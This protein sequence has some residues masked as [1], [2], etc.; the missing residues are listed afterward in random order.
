MKT[1]LKVL[2]PHAI[3]LSILILVNLIY[4][5]PQFQGKQ[6]A[7]GDVISFNGAYVEIGK[8]ASEKG[9]QLF[10]TN[11][12]F[13]GMPTYMIGINLKSFYLDWVASYLQLKFNYPMGVFLA[14]MIAFYILMTVMG[15]SPYLS[16]I[17]AIAFGF[18]TN[19]FVLFEAGHNTK[20][21]TIV[22][23]PLVLAGLFLLYT[24]RKYIFGG[25]LFSVATA[26][27]LYANHPQMTY[28]FIMSC[29]ILAVFW[30]VQ[31]IKEKDFNHLAKT[32]LSVTIGASLA[33]AATSANV[34]IALDYS[35]DTLRGK[36]I[37]KNEATGQI[38]ST[39]AASVENP[40]DGLTWDYAMQW[41]NNF[42]DVLSMLIPSAAGGSSNE[43][44]SKGETFTLLKNGGNAV[45]SNGNM[46]LPLYCGALPFTSGP[47]Y[48]GASMI[49]LF[50]LGF[51]LE[52]GSL[53]W[54]L[55]T[56]FLL[57]ALL[58][59]GKNFSMLQTLFFDYLPLYN[60]FRAPSSILT[61]TPLFLPILGI[62]GLN[63][64]IYRKYS[65]ESILKSLKTAFF[66]TGG[67][68]LFFL[69]FGTSFFGFQGASDSQ[70]QPQLLTTLI[71]DRKAFF[72]ADA[73]RSLLIVMGI[74][75]VI[76][77]F[78]KNWF[79]PSV[80]ILSIGLVVLFDV[81]GIGARY[82]SKDKFQ[83]SS[84]ANTPLLERPV[85][86]QIKQYEKSRGD[87]RVL[88]LSVNVFNN[89]T[90]SY[91]HNTI[92]GYHA[93][94]LM[95]YNDIIEKQISNNN[96]NVI[97]MLNAKYI[98]KQ[99]QTV[100][101]NPLACGT[102]WFIDTIRKV[103]TPNEEMAAL[104]NFNPQEEAIILDNEFNGYVGNFDP[105]KGGEI[106][107]T[108]YDPQN[109]VYSYSAASPQFAVF[110][111]IWYGPDKGWQA[112]I[113]DK[114]VD[115]VRVNYLLRGLKVPEGKHT[116]AFRFKPVKIQQYITI[117]RAASGLLMVALLGMIGWMGFNFYKN[118][119]ETN[120]FPS[121]PERPVS[122]VSRDTKPSPKTSSVQQNKKPG[123]KN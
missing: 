36:P 20:L 15:I 65:T 85:D 72:R 122:P 67:I 22:F 46:Q 75:S 54:W 116:I 106:S 23:N 102:S 61:I 40:T 91:H 83:P 123:K 64:I 104:N 98:I 68:L 43:E 101:Q 87:Y 34:F 119:G 41:S 44:V 80:A 26:S 38:Q 63:G 95:R 57:T 84:Q 5:L 74:A 6:V 110:S 115:H 92:G 114:P 35:K 117:S 58:S 81:W 19:N 4:F 16:V 113:D 78:I 25:I 39:G 100:S 30:L 99:D 12:M 51:L 42:Q 112:F 76:Y 66:I 88:D 109:L 9:E 1:H 8:Y 103:S 32:A 97:N 31:S 55:L 13:G 3:C 7:Q 29:V 90:T 73:I 47:N 120:P 11:A 17:G 24:K 49:F 33:L 108:Q 18:T 105:Q 48:L 28:Y 53:R 14:Q 60:K 50:L 89:S 27:T 79:N 71:Q 45:S 94:K 70:L 93:A 10:W 59:L 62:L 86:Q 69:L 2:T 107:L 37:L 121:A 21:G 118:P 111:E 82:L 56:S 96:Q 77:A 52:K